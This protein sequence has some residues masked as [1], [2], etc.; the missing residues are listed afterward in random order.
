YRCFLAFHTVFSGAFSNS[1]TA[2]YQWKNLRIQQVRFGLTADIRGSATGSTAKY[3]GLKVC[4][5]DL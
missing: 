1:T 3:Q 4:F 2:R 5:A